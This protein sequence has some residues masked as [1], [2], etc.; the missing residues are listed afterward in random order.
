MIHLSYPL[1]ILVDSGCENHLALSCE[2]FS[3]LLLNCGVVVL[4]LALSGQLL[5]DKLEPI[6]GQCFRQDIIIELKLSV[7]VLRH[8][9]VG[10][11]IN[12]KV[13]IKRLNFWNQI[14]CFI[15]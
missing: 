9:I 5:S 2:S 7:S 3:D 12:P 1:P 14:H 4:A 11:D 10:V 13:V 15:I 6:C 8:E